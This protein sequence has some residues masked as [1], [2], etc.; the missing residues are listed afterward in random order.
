MDECLKQAFEK[1]PMDFLEKF[2]EAIPE[3]IT[4]G[5]LGEMFTLNS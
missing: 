5:F 4:K 3:R 1:F 2:P